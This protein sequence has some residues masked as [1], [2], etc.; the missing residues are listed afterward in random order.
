MVR[1]EGLF[2]SVWLDDPEIVRDGNYFIAYSVELKLVGCG[3]S[4][5]QA[6]ENLDEVIRT[7][8]RTLISVGSLEKTL[9]EL[10]IPF[11]EILPEQQKT[12]CNNKQMLVISR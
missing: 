2:F 12:R 5:L 11:K 8:L 6:R 3:A 4:E 9:T 7:N 1:T 10:G